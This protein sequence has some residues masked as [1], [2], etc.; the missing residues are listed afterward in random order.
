MNLIKKRIFSLW[1]SLCIL[2]AVNAQETEL[3]YCNK[4]IHKTLQA[5]GTSS[6][7]PRSMDAYKLHWN[8][9]SVDDWTSG[10]FPGTGDKRKSRLFH[11]T[12]R[13]FIP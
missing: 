3:T 11:Q 4:Q 7:I 9:V 6:K 2:C 8:M 5:I 1:A 13:T 10:F 12:V